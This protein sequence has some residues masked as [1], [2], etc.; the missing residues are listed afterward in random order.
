LDVPEVID[1]QVVPPSVDVRYS[2]PVRPEPASVEADAVAVREA[3]LCHAEEPPDTVGSLGALR[4]SFAVPCT[5]EELLPA[6]STAR[7]RTS[8]WPSAETEVELPDCGADQVV[9]PSVDVSYS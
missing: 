1:D 7:K 3:T 4:S 8:V 6:P 9:P 5:Q 2:Y